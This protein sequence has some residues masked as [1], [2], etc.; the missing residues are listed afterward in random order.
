MSPAN[1]KNNVSNKKTFEIQNYS[2]KKN[3][4]LKDPMYF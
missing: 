3:V 2:G 1:F 4:S